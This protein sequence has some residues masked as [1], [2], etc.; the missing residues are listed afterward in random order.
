MPSESSESLITQDTNIIYPQSM[1]TTQVAMEKRLRAI[2]KAQSI[3]CK[4]ANVI[5]TSG[6]FGIIGGIL[7]AGMVW[8]W[9]AI[10]HAWESQAK[11]EYT[12]A[13]TFSLIFFAIG[14]ISFF[15]ASAIILILNAIWMQRRNVDKK[16]YPDT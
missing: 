6:T 15:I 9:F 8:L 7:Y 11:F 3:G 5:L 16:V 1:S 2:T 14:V 13:F 4:I 12:N 10:K